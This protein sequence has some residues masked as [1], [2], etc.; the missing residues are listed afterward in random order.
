MWA[1]TKCG[2]RPGVYRWRPP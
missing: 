2:G 1:I